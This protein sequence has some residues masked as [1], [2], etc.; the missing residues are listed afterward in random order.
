MLFLGGTAVRNLLANTGGTRDMGLIP[1]SV[2]STGVVK[3]NPFQYS[4]LEILMNIEA[5]WATVHEVAKI[6]T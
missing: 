1:G 5:W 2:I 3:S 6:W 4:C